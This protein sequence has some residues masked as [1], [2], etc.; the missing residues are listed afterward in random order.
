VIGWIATLLCIIA[1]LLVVKKRNGFLLWFVGT[2]I[3][4]ILAL[5]DCNW[6]QVFLFLTY[7][8]INIFGYVK[9]KQDK[10]KLKNGRS[11]R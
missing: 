9:W 2:G 11:L 10:Y 6:S 7:E 4:L 3:L 5:L 1:N 8:I